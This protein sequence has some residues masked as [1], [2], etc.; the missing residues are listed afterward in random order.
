MAV[1]A[2]KSRQL[3]LCRMIVERLCSMD[4]EDEQAAADL[5]DFAKAHEAHVKG[6][7]N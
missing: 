5:V 7:G 6:L 3:G 2:R 1:E 4:P